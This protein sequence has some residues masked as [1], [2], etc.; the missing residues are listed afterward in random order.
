MDDNT[1]LIR[2]LHTQFQIALPE[3]ITED[4]LLK[5]L[6]GYIDRLI[7]HDFQRLV[8]IL[9][10]TDVSEERLT[11]ILHQHSGEQAATII[12]KLIIEREGEKMASRKRFSA[13]KD[14][15]DEES[16]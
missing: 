12:A 6:S 13:K 11:R 10:K 16:W 4:E 9:Y 1:L 7:Q 3:Q 2:F 14:V 5:R 15:P 8:T